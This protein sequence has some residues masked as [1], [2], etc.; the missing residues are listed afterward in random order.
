MRNNRVF[1]GDLHSHCNISY[2][3]GKLTHAVYRASKQL[4]FCTITGHAFC[5]DI[6]EI[7]HL[8]SIKNYHLRGFQKLKK[9][10]NKILADLKKLEKKYIINIFPSYEW[11][12]LKYGDHNVIDKNFNL[13]LISADNIDTL[14]KSISKDS[15]V[16]PIILVM[17]KIKE[18]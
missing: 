13:K 18:V 8:K 17:E 16:I 3:D 9:K 10:W 15:F 1:W 6:S 4:D 7:N 2:G 5:P 12:S 14:K 11:H